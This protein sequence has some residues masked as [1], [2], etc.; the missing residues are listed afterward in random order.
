MSLLRR[1]AFDAGDPG[2]TFVQQRNMLMD[3]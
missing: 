1:P 3:Q 2:V